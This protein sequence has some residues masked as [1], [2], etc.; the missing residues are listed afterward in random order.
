MSALLSLT[1]SDWVSRMLVMCKDV[2]LEFLL[3]EAADSMFDVSISCQMC[4][5]FV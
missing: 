2:D 5:A 4:C 1:S 3:S